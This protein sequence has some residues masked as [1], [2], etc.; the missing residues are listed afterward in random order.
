[1]PV[2][3]T[4]IWDLTIKD[5]NAS[6]QIDSAFHII[7]ELRRVDRALLWIR[8]DNTCPMYKDLDTLLDYALSPGSGESPLEIVM[9]WTSSSL[10]ESRWALFRSR[11]LTILLDSP[12]RLPN[13]ARIMTA[14]GSRDECQ[15][16]PGTYWKDKGNGDHEEIFCHGQ[17]GNRL[18]FELAR[19]PIV[20][21]RGIV[22]PS[23]LALDMQMGDIR[24]RPLTNILSRP[25]EAAA[26]AYLPAVLALPRTPCHILRVPFFRPQAEDMG[27]DESLFSL[28]RI[29]YQRL[30]EQSA[31]TVRL[32]HA[33]QHSDGIIAQIF[34]PESP[35]LKKVL[36]LVAEKGSRSARLLRFAENSG[37]WDHN[38]NIGSF[39]LFITGEEPFVPRWIYDPE[40][41]RGLVQA[42]WLHRL[43]QPWP[44][45]T[46][47][48]T[49]EGVNRYLEQINQWLQK[50]HYD[51]F[52]IW[53]LPLWFSGMDA[54][55]HVNPSSVIEEHF[56]PILNI[57]WPYDLIASQA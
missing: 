41:H 31:L 3:P 24:S 44:D 6:W 17:D 23:P 10:S 34:E 40:S 15:R 11:P 26:W 47:L 37:E 19:T 33:L 32:I 38:Y 14:A 54:S 43:V 39:L 21:A 55:G 48:M 36:E 45:G 4:L 28:M 16:Q 25:S 49:D 18:T 46:A 52:G 5:D 27:L 22:H 9:E 42:A 1:M 8:V 53:S 29:N 50:E 30:M 7:S 20:T 57:V 56:G 12:S 2:K 35:D 51:A 13:S